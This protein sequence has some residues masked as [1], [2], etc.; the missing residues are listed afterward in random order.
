MENNLSNWAELWEPIVK[1]F[2]TVT[3]KKIPELLK[4]IEKIGF[5][6]LKSK[7]DTVRETGTE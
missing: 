6:Q 3:L 4:H 1:R 7:L 2:P 5:E